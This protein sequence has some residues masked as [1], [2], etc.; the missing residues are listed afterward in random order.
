MINVSKRV[1]AFVAL[2]FA[3]FWIGAVIRL[4]S[5]QSALE[6]MKLYTVVIETVDAETGQPIPAGVTGPSRHTIAAFPADVRYTSLPNGE[7]EVRWIGIKPVKI[8]VDSEGYEEQ[9]IEVDQNSPWKI[10]VKLNKL[11]QQK[12][13]APEP[14]LQ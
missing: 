9:T 13:E 10:T 6:A 8:T 2:V 1:L 3:V 11:D 14:A 7:M 4:S 12:T 5:L